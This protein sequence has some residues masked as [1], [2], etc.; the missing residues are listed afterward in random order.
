MTASKLLGAVVVASLFSATAAVAGTAF[1]SDDEAREVAGKMSKIITDQGLEAGIEAMHDPAYPFATSEMGIHVFEGSVIVA[2]NREPELIA[3][4]YAEVQ[5][6]TEEPMWPRI[7]QA[8]HKRSDAA[9]KWYHYDTEEI[10]D[11]HCYSEWAV[12]PEILV[13]VCR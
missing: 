11:Y 3:T 6:L 9:L 2:D 8:A 10:Y 7:V 13:M 5:D 12:E 4:S 1:G